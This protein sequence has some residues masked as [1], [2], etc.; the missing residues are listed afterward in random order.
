MAI[1]I[2]F[3]ALSLFLLIG[4][5]VYVRLKKS[6]RKSIKQRKSIIG[7]SKGKFEDIFQVTIKDNIICLGNRYS[8]IVSL[9]NIDYNILS[10]EEKSTIE[11]KLTRIARAIDYPIQFYTTTEFIDTSKIIRYMNQSKAKSE[12]VQ[13]YKEHLMTFLQNLM[14]NRVVSII[15]S[16]AIISYDGLYETDKNVNTIFKR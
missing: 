10:E 3:L 9:G 12:K 2:I 14:D 16:Y 5:I 11:F 8:K 15:K 4:T 1:M 7:E 13:E 6:N